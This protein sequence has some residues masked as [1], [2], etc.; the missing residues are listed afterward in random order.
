MLRLTYIIKGLNYI[1]TMFQGM[2]RSN[3]KRRALSHP[4]NMLKESEQTLKQHFQTRMSNKG[5]SEE[6]IN[7]NI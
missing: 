2:V 7:F 4:K 5:P 6:K 1:S 3:I